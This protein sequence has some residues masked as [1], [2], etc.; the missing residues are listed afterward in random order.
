MAKR[1]RTESVQEKL[2]ERQAERGTFNGIPRHHSIV[3][4]TGAELKQGDL[5]VTRINPRTGKATSTQE[6]REIEHRVRGCGNVHVNKKDC[7]DNIGKVDILV[8][9][10]AE[11]EAALLGFG[12]LEDDYKV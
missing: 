12:D 6:I 9:L 1:Q 5:I 10:T 2:I 8:K 7:Y 11:E 4:I 3:T